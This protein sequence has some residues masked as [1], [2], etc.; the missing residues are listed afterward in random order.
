MKRA[1][2]FMLLGL[3]VIAM[4]GSISEETVVAKRSNQ[5]YCK[6]HRKHH[7]KKITKKIRHKAKKK[8]VWVVD[9]KAYDEPIYKERN[10]VI[11]ICEKEFKFYDEWVAHCDAALDDGDLTH[12]SYRI[13]PRQIKIG[14][15]HHAEQGHYKWKVIKPVWTEKKV[16]GYRCHCGKRCY[17]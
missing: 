3:L 16:V 1:L 7:W 14:T 2:V 12:G 10:M 11:C 6:K 8:K 4:T 17:K 9:Q 13:E 5:D 15:K